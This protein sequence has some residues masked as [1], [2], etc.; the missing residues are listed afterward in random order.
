MWPRIWVRF[1]YKAKRC[2]TL[3]LKNECKIE[4]QIESQIESHVLGYPGLGVQ[5]GLGAVTRG[6][7]R[8]G[9]RAGGLELRCGLRFRPRFGLRFW[10]GAGGL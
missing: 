9:A 1:S 10:A 8:L 7:P 2:K 4:C 5:P 3:G 6:G